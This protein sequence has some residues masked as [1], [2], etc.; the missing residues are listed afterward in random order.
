MTVFQNYAAGEPPDEIDGAQ[1]ILWA[2]NPQTPFFSMRYSDGT[3]CKPIHGLAI[4]RYQGE[5]RY[6]RFSCDLTWNVANDL[7]YDSL[8]EAVKAA[9]ALSA[10]PLIWNK[11]TAQK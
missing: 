2:F 3:T 5:K 7:D 1:V 8:E 11:K 6:Y 10:Q 9:D 4:C